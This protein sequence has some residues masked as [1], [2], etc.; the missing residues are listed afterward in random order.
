MSAAAVPR[1]SAILGISAGIIGAATR[2]E[3]L[4]KRYGK[5]A[6]VDGLTIWTR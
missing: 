5:R 1:L 6:E 2:T 3:R 4:A